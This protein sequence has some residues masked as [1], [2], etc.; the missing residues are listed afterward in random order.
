MSQFQMTISDLKT[1]KRVVGACGARVRGGDG[2]LVIVHGQKQ[3]LQGDK[4]G[5]EYS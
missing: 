2:D 5:V 1:I 4:M 3:P